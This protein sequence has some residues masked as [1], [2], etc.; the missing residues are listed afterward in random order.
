MPEFHGIYLYNRS[1][2]YIVR[3]FAKACFINNISG[4]NPVSLTDLIEN[5]PG[6]LEGI[7]GAQLA[8]EMVKQATKYGLKLSR[9]K[10][11]A[12]RYFQAASGWAVSMVK[13]LPPELLS[14]PAVPCQR[15]WEYPVKMNSGIRE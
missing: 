14:S 11:A 4:N 5:Y 3:D 9:L 15:S 10:L 13:A 8:T 2:K 1:K 12:S 7:A 6:F